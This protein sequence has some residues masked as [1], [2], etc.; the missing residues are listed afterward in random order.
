[1][2][3]SKKEVEEL[4][5]FFAE[6]SIPKEVQL[7]QGIRIIDTHKFLA[8][9]FEVVSKL[10]GKPINDVFYDRLVRLRSILSTR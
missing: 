8:S 3:F 6:I 7:Y 5:Q 4:K 1:M 9:H 10:D 2:S